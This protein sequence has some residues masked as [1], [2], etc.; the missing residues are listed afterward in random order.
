[1]GDNLKVISAEFSNLSWAV[2]DMSVAAQHRQAS[3]HL[4]LK[5]YTSGLY[6]QDIMTIL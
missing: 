6:H 2:F 1:M 4:E 3:L 5:T